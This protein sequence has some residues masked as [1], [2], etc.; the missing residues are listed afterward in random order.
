MICGQ[1]T[2]SQHT[3]C[4]K[5]Q[6]DHKASRR[7]R[8]GAGGDVGEDGSPEPRTVVAGLAQKIAVE[9]LVGKHIVA[10]LMS[11]RSPWT[12]WLPMS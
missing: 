7:D 10:R 6:I 9:D 12:R 3:C 8:E 5:R 1:L 4:A 2:P 11:L